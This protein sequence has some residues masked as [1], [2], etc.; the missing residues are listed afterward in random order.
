MGG[1]CLT[2]EFSWSRK[3]P[4]TWTYSFG[5]E[6]RRSF[7]GK[8]YVGISN[9]K[10]YDSEG[11]T[12]FVWRVEDNNPYHGFRTIT[13]DL[14]PVRPLSVQESTLEFENIQRDSRGVKVCAIYAHRVTLV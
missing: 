11:S 14:D 5:G 4:Q 1:P 10:D 8:K 12:H 7:R 6:L 9:V 3:V 13:G 2:N